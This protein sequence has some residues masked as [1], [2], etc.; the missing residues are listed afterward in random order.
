[1]PDQGDFQR[2]VI[3]T[4]DDGPDPDSTPE[5]LRVLRD[6]KD[7]DGDPA[8]VKATFFVLGRQLRGAQAEAIITEMV[9]DGHLVG[10]HTDS[11]L[12]LRQ[13]STSAA[14]SQVQKATEQLTELGFESDY[15]RFPYGSASCAKVSLVQSMDYRVTGWHVDSADWCFASSKGGVGHCDARTFKY[16]DDDYRDDMVGLILSQLEIRNGGILL[17]HDVHDNTKEM[18]PNILQ[19]LDEAGYQYTHLS[20]AG[21]LPLLNRQWIGSPCDDKHSCA[22]NNGSQP[23]A[24]L[25]VDPITNA[26]FCS[27]P[28][29][30]YC[31]DMAGQ[32]PTFCVAVG[33]A[34][35]GSCVPQAVEENDFCNDLAGT[36]VQTADRFIGDSSAP[37]KRSEVCLP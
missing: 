8:P 37:D 7:A 1:M 17:M 25:E 22:F 4:F 30:G 11:H 18:L 10:N 15:F 33:E 14:R 23:S 20:D 32:A 36:K 31:P 28:C 19:A 35:T 34:Q 9:A 16:V 24:C 26:G 6:H 21:T 12:N 27:L 29:E 5:V 13:L 3:L 2:K